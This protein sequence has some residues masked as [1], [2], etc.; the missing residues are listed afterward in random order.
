MRVETR[1]DREGENNIV[2]MQSFRGLTSLSPIRQAEAYWSALR[3]GAGIPRR[4]QIDP[5]GLENILEYAFI[6]ERIA[7]GIARFR[8]AGQHLNRAAGMEVRGMPLTA[9]FVPAARDAIADALEQVF[10]TPAVAELALTG[11][12][13]FAQP[14]SEAHMIMLPL[15]SDLGEIS[16]ALG[17]LVREDDLGGRR[18]FDDATE[19]GFER[20][21]RRSRIGHAHGPGHHMRRSG[22]PHQFDDE[23]AVQRHVA[24]RNGEVGIA[25]G[26][27][28][29]RPVGRRSTPSET[30]ASRGLNSASRRIPVS[31]SGLQV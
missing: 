30:G 23:D 29:C 28:Q 4:T 11:E 18:R 2:D 12:P 6:L 31:T 20:G 17:V 24:R 8:L 26:A 21:A 1:S 16:R 5:R 25:A 10:G 14:A 19:E 22:R 3:E 9:F 13:R 15:K 7:P 27:G